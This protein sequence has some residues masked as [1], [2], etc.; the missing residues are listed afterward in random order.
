[1]IR[2]NTSGNARAQEKTPGHC[3]MKKEAVPPVLLPQDRARAQELL[4]TIL[5]F[6]ITPSAGH[7]DILLTIPMRLLG[8]SPAGSVSAAVC[9]QHTAVAT[10]DP[11]PNPQTGRFDVRLNTPFGVASVAPCGLLLHIRAGIHRVPHLSCV[12]RGRRRFPIGNRQSNRVNHN[13]LPAHFLSIAHGCCRSSAPIPRCRQ[14]VC[15]R[16]GSPKSGC[17]PVYNFCDCPG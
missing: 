12:R 17:D 9:Q 15:S 10:G 3:F 13:H 5:E 6:M 8:V 14:P 11:R 4:A 1:M 2:K 7:R 16:R